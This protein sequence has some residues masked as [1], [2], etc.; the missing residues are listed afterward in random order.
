MLS[1]VIIKFSSVIISSSTWSPQGSH[2]SS[3]RLSRSFQ[4]YHL[5]HC[6]SCTNGHQGLHKTLTLLSFEQSVITVVIPFI[7]KLQLDDQNRYHNIVTILHWIFDWITLYSSW[8]SIFLRLVQTFGSNKSNHDS[9]NVDVQV[10]LTLRLNAVI[11]DYFYT[12]NSVYTYH[13]NAYLY[14]ASSKFSV[15][16]RVISVIIKNHDKI[17]TSSDQGH[18][19][20]FIFI[21][22]RTNR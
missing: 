16:T 1:D 12:C 11:L 14:K 7:Y 8:L 9:E 4:G 5:G 15:I 17:N 20:N 6:K 21:I 3:F 18:Q 19:Q 22:K 10:G 2:H 13:N